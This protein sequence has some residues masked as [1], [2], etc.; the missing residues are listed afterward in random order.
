MIVIGVTAIVIISKV[1]FLLSLLYIQ[2]YVCLHFQSLLLSLWLIIL[3]PHSYSANSYF[4]YIPILPSPIL[5]IFL[6][7]KIFVSSG[8]QKSFNNTTALQPFHILQK[9]PRLNFSLKVIERKE[10]NG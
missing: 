7:C 9:E 5:H 6:F 1:I 2:I 8:N 4:A 3:L 10:G